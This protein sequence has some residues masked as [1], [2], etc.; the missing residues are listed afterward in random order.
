[1][2]SLLTDYLVQQSKGLLE[3]REEVSQ[4]N[5]PYQMF[6]SD[7]WE[8]DGG[9][10]EVEV[11]EFL[12]SLVRLMKP[13]FV[14]ETGTHA[15]ISSMYMGQAIKDN[16]QGKVYTVEYSPVWCQRAAQLHRNAGVN[17]TIVQASSLES[18]TVATM[19][20]DIDILFLDTEPEIRYK[21]FET[22]FRNVKPGGIIMIHDL[23]PNMSYSDAGPNPDHPHLGSFWPFGD[24]RSTIGIKLESQEIVPIHFKT[25][26]GFSLYYKVDLK[27]DNDWAWLTKRKYLRK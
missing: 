4:P 5:G 2:S 21:E 25:P 23:H 26:R 19:V 16:E 18:A 8:Q 7:T 27:E 15:G 11:G 6:H 12:Y 10:V 17:V 20:D 14:L 22:Y 13:N 9:S 1:M 3:I 24:F